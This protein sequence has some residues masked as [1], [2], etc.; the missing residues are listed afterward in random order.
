MKQIEEILKNREFK[1]DIFQHQ[2]DAL[3]KANLRKGF[4]Y[5]MEQGTGKT[6]TV[7]EEFAIFL[8]KGEVDSLVIVCPNSVK[9]VWKYEL[10]KH[11]NQELKIFIWGIDNVVD[12]KDFDVLI[13]NYDSIRK[14]TKGEAFIYS[15]VKR[16]INHMFVAD[17]GHFIKNYKSK[18][19]KAAL[20]HS[21]FAKY[22][23]LLTGTPIG[24]SLID[25]YSQLVFIDENIF[26]GMSYLSFIYRYCIKGGFQGKQI[27]GYRKVD[28]LKKIIEKNSFK[29]KKTECLD[30]PEKT[31]QKIYIELDSIQK[32]KYNAE[33][34][35]II[36]NYESQKTKKSSYALGLLN[37]ARQLSGGTLK[38][39]FG[40][41]VVHRAKIDA[42]IEFVALMASEGKKI[43]IWCEY[44]GEVKELRSGLILRGL[45]SECVKEI[46]GS[47]VGTR[48]KT[49][50]EFKEQDSCVLILQSSCGSTGLT[51]NEATASVFFSNSFSFIQ[52]N[53][54]EDR[55]HRI[56]QS[57][58]VTYYDFVLQ[59]SVDV[60]ILEAHKN[61]KDISK[62]V[63]SGKDSL[64]EFV[65]T[66]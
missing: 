25:I 62:L 40:V 63:L 42:C 8:E 53:Q 55:N 3:I 9:N 26:K 2:K 46:T 20:R 18:Q 66:I 32:K 34:E 56:G 15:F 47:N 38:E 29:I 60:K 14:N 37:K 21:Q 52:R 36:L 49:L 59:D 65:K 12:K 7:I 24:N 45:S 51:L 6:K 58:K 61:K 39:E 1:I 64:Q 41:K 31:Y 48:G 43:L 50:E 17:E 27:V 28:E 54:A 22:R 44:L 57:E 5:F 13:I 23:R 33:I 30:L 35:K 4:A 16:K 10:E 19:T 11:L